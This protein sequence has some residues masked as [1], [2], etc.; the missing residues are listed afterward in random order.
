MNESLEVNAVPQGNSEEKL[1]VQIEP[2]VRERV[3]G[4]IVSAPASSDKKALL[5][6]KTIVAKSF[7]EGGEDLFEELLDAMRTA[8]YESDEQL[9]E[10]ATR[11]ITDALTKLGLRISP[12][13][14]QRRF[15]RREN[16]GFEKT[17]L[18]TN[19]MFTYTRYENTIEMHVKSFGLEDVLNSEKVSLL[20]ERFSE[21]ASALA[22]IVH[23]DESIER[24]E[25]TSWIV[26]KYRRVV[27]KELGF[28][29]VELN[30]EELKEIEK[31]F[32]AE[33][34]GRRIGRAVMT[35]EDFLKKYGA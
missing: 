31:H 22:G 32:P 26:A 16:E 24:I 25:L 11:E 35:R 4:M 15:R 23:A 27:E 29:L 13:E 18:D 9:E 3:R 1:R 2:A 28:T 21:A 34:K 33:L 8:R 14:L 7:F 30:E 19:G 10:I 12:L 5:I 17:V 6:E 20:R